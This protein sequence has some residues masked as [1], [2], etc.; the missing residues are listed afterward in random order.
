MVRCV[1]ACINLLTRNLHA[2]AFGECE[3]QQVS[4]AKF[5]YLWTLPE[6]SLSKKI[7]N[8]LVKTTQRLHYHAGQH[9]GQQVQRDVVI[10]RLMVV[11]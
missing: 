5:I 2:S 4:A 3:K 9:Q 7:C 1:I 6:Y 11:C 8:K 10:S